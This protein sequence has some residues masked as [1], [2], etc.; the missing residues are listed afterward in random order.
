MIGDQGIHRL[1]DRIK[2]AKRQALDRIAAE[3]AQLLA[4]V[5]KDWPVKK[6]RSRRAFKVVSR[7]SGEKVQGELTNDAPH[8][9]WIRVGRVQR[10]WDALVLARHEER[11]DLLRRELSEILGGRRG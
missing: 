3:P 8:L 11:K 6:G 9:P 5:E 1:V 4:D 2:R 10:A 7:R